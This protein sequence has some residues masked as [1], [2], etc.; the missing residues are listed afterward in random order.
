[1]SKPWLAASLLLALSA[2]MSACAPYPLPADFKDTGGRGDAEGDIRRGSAFGVAIGADR[3]AARA[4]MLKDPRIQLN[5]TG[6]CIPE[7]ARSGRCHPNPNVDKFLV[8]GFPFGGSIFVFYR[9]GKVREIR[10]GQHSFP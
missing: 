7:L 2:G 4:Q 3:E 6:D 5:P 10:W 9:A 8:S 1:M